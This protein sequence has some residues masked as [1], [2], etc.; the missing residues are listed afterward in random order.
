MAVLITSIKTLPVDG[1]FPPVYEVVVGLTEMATAEEAPMGREWRGVR[2]LKD[3]V[4]R[5]VD[6][7]CF[8]PCRGAPEEEDHVLTMAVDRLD[9]SVSEGL[10]AE[11]LVAGSPAGGD[12]EC[13]VE[14]EDA[15]LS[16]GEK[17]PI[18]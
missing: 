5:A 13:R 14:E 7:T 15:L 6:H 1:L 8:A 12:G 18:G 3:E 2:R 16:P 17:M 4:A 10:P 11:S 9:D